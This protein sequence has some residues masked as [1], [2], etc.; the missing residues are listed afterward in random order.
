MI[1]IQKAGSARTPISLDIFKDHETDWVFRR[2]LTFTGEKAAELGECISAALEI[3]EKDGESWIKA[4]TDLAARV[5]DE[6]NDSLEKGHKIS[7]RECLLRACNYYRTAEYGT[8]PNDPRFDHLWNKSRECFQKAGNLFNPPIEPIEIDFQ[9]KKLPGYFWRPDNSQK[10]RPTLVAAGGN[11]SSGEEVVLWVGMAAVRRGYNFFMF[12]HPGH[13]GALHLY[14][15]C[16]RR[17]D[18]EIPY[19]EAF[20]LLETFPGVD[21]RIALTGYSFGGYV[22]I[23]VAAF[24]KRVKAVIPN[25]PVLD[26]TRMTPGWSKIIDY[27][28]YSWID[29]LVDWK[30]KQTPI[31]RAWIEYTALGQGEYGL[32]FS[33]IVEKRLGSVKKGENL[34]EQ[35][36]SVNKFVITPDILS[37]IS[38]PALGMVSEDEGKDFVRQAEEFYQGISSADKDLHI[39]K[40]KKDGSNDHCQLDNRSRGT[41]VMFDWLDNVFDYRDDVLRGI[42]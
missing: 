13:R 37:E 17:Y 10:P 7:A 3:D 24:E 38:C 31:K 4:W 5:E 11:D 20:D 19:K 15:E 9:G 30:M 35:L 34:V 21:E 27:I 39:F 28:P 14:P 8:L 41:Q 2:T 33:E 29:R 6:G 12:E 22:A 16:I 26:I 40:L 32:T 42:I 25:N 23:R 36:K 1:K 18:Y